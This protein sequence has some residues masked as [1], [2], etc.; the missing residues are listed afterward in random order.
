MSFALVIIFVSTMT[1]ILLF[2]LLEQGVNYAGQQK[3]IVYLFMNHPLK[4]EAIVLLLFLSVPIYFVVPIYESLILG[5]PDSS[6]WTLLFLI[7]G[8][9]PVLSYMLHRRLLD[10]KVTLGIGKKKKYDPI[11][12]AKINVGLWFAS[13]CLLVVSLFL[14]A[15]S[16]LPEIG[17]IMTAAGTFGLLFIPFRKNRAIIKE[18]NESSSDEA[19]LE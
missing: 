4:F 6:G 8:G 3:R 1:A 14:V 12:I 10:F 11:L 18:Y 2:L 13:A 16:I 9:W 5:T 15:S 7:G 17:S 19:I